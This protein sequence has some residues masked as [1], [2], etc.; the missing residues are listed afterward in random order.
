[1][2]TNETIRKADLALG[3]LLKHSEHESKISFKELMDEIIEE[4]KSQI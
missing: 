2:T 1:M 4:W 3:V